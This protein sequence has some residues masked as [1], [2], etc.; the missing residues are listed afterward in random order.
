MVIRESPV[1]PTGLFFM[2]LERRAVR[3]ARFFVPRSR[4]CRQPRARQSLREIH[5]FRFDLSYSP[6]GFLRVKACVQRA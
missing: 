5:H 1:A 3:I 4:R 6:R 2:S